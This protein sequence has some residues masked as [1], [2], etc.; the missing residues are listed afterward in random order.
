MAWWWLVVVCV[1][2]GARNPLL[3]V[4]TVVVVWSAAH[5]HLQLPPVLFRC[6]WDSKAASSPSPPE[7]VL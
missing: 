1:G 5:T 2:G 3:Q 4:E 6:F 7:H